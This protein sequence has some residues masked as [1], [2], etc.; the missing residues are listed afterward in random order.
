MHGTGARFSS[1]NILEHADVRTG[2]KEMFNWPTFPQLYIGGKLVGGL[3]VMKELDSEGELKAMMPPEVFAPAPSAAGS[4]ASL[5]ALV[6]KSPVMLFMKGTAEQPKCG[7]SSS[8]VQLLREQG[9]Q[10]EAF[11]ILA[12]S[13]V[14]EG[15]KIYSNWPTFPQL[16]VEGKLLGGLDV[17][18]ELAEEGALLDAILPR[19]RK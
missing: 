8:M 18:R 7:F 13:A 16:Y 11:D 15:L 5:E 12:D 2:L 10:F 4:P 19:H 17:A 9:V 14:R 3:D 1:F 6:R